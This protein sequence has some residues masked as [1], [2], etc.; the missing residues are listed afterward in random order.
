MTSG[1]KVTSITTQFSTRS[2]FNE[3]IEF[4]SRLYRRLFFA[5]RPGGGNRLHPLERCTP[6]CLFIHR[7]AV[8]IALERFERR[9]AFRIGP[10][11]GELVVRARVAPRKPFVFGHVIARHQFSPADDRRRATRSISTSAPTASA[12]TPTVVRAGSRSSGK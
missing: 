12:V 7:L 1:W 9:H 10:P 2:Q 6:R 4:L 5:L 11:D 8:L 3:Y